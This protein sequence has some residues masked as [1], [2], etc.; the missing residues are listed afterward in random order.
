V[1]VV[2]GSEIYNFPNHHFEHFYSTFWSFSFS[3]RA[4]RISCR[5]AATSH[6][7]G[8]QARP[9]SRAALRVACHPRRL[10]R[11]R[12]SPGVAPSR[13][14]P[15]L[16]G[17]A[18]IRARRVSLPDARIRWA[19]PALPALPCRRTTFLPGSASGHVGTSR[20]SGRPSLKLIPPASPEV[21]VPS[22]LLL[23]PPPATMAATVELHLPLDFVTGQPFRRLL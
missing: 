3:K 22:P 23:A 19:L 13:G 10:S 11:P 17:A 12:T 8:L 9:R 7:S 18:E 4:S 1:K 15:A 2:E 5:C 16:R 14:K 20:S 6:L 21:C